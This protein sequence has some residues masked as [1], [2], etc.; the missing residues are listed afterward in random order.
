M[1]SDF[2]AFRD[3]LTPYATGEYICR[4]LPEED[5]LLCTSVR[6]SPTSASP[7]ASDRVSLSLIIWDGP[8][9]ATQRANL[10]YDFLRDHK[11]KGDL[12]ES[13]RTYLERVMG[14]VVSWVPWEDI[15]G[16]STAKQEIA[17]ALLSSVVRCLAAARANVTQLEAT[18]TASAAIV[19]H[20]ARDTTYGDAYVPPPQPP[21]KRTT[22]TVAVAG[23][24]L[25]HP[26]QKVRKVTPIQIGK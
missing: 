19:R 18:V 22:A 21:R 8:R 17:N 24:S 14:S 9:G 5:R 26:S 23:G 10:S 16:K 20:T 7:C 15:G 12:S 4:P 3:A 2:D 1:S 6:I 11:E 25:L 13:W